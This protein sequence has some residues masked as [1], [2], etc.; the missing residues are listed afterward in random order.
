MLQ[1]A[2]GEPHGL[3]PIAELGADDYDLVRPAEKAGASTIG[4]KH[5][6][7]LRSELLFSTCHLEAIFNSPSQLHHFSDYLVCHRAASLPLLKYYLEALK[8]LKALEYSN[9]V[10]RRLGAVSRSCEE[11]ENNQE[12]DSAETIAASSNQG[13][14]D[15]VQAAFELMVQQDL[16]MYITHVWIQTVSASIRHRITSTPARHMNEGLA[17]VFCLT[18]P[19]RPDNP[20]VFMSEEFNRTTQYGVDYVVGRNCRFLQGP[21][22]NALSV[23]RIRERLAQGKEHYETFL[24]YRRDGSPFMNLVMV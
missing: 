10:V 2:H 7:E 4:K 24:N 16:P 14:V 13:L 5:K 22:T 6:L 3:D 23:R 15:A 20:I 1:I 21:C 11:P 19:S 18:D 8:A 9:A 12:S 17:E